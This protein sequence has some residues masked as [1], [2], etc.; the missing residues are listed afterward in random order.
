MRTKR[1]VVA[2]G[3]AL[4]VTTSALAHDQAMRAKATHGTVTAVHGEHLSVETDKG[5]IDVTLTDETR[6]E[7][8]EKAVG[9]DTIAPGAHVAIFGTKVPGQ[10]LVAKSIE[11]TEAGPAHEEGEHH[12]KH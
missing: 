11:L 12:H 5:S 3:A 8:N 6:V 1:L 4:M 7:R 9:R 10:G 2:V